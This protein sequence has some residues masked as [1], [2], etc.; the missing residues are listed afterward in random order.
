MKKMVIVIFVSF[1]F[2]ISS[3][4]AKAD[5]GDSVKTFLF[6]QFEKGYVVLKEGNAQLP[7]QLNYDL[8]EERMLYIEAEDVMNE[9]NAEAVMAVVIGGH[10][11]FPAGKKQSFYERIETDNNKEYYV[12][13][14]TKALSKGKASSYGT[15]SQTASVSGLAVTNSNGN[16]YLLGPDEKI[17]GID[18]SAVFIKNG[19]K[20]EKINSLK[21]LVKFF[22]SH[23]AEIEAYS[24]ENKTN[25]NKIENVKAIIHYSFSLQ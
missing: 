16:L 11:F 24:N 15:Y 21:S 14:K 17:E 12:G 10:S 13:H 18:E 7:A 8:I 22:K 6:P 20:F 2:A 4:H 25:F 3:G 19:K 23:Q 5:D 9:L 1:I